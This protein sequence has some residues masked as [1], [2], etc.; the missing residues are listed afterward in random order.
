[1]SCSGSGGAGQDGAGAGGEELLEDDALLPTAEDEELPPHPAVLR[2]RAMSPGN[3]IRRI[4]SRARGCILVAGRGALEGTAPELSH[5]AAAGDR[6]A[7]AQRH[8]LASAG[9]AGSLAR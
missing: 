7:A 5:P 1:V 9:G 8:A 6:R 3:A 4:M 2:H